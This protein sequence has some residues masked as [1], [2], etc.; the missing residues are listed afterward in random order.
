M[1]PECHADDEQDLGVHRLDEGGMTGEDHP[2]Y[3]WEP[4]VRLP[5]APDKA[6][7]A[8]SLVV[9]HTQTAPSR[10]RFAYHKRIVTTRR[11]DPRQVPPGRV[12][13]L[14]SGGTFVVRAA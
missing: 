4:G 14:I 12:L 6:E 1:E 9:W 7:I 10:D 13:S 5:G 3:L 11:F 2:W 8:E